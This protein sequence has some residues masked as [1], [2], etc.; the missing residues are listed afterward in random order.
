MRLR[1]NITERRATSVGCAVN[2]GTISTRR[3]HSIASSALIPTRRISHR[4]PA[5][6][7][8]WR[9]AAAAQSQRN[10]PALAMIRLRQVDELEVKC[11]RPREQNGPLHRQRVHQ[12][13]RTRRVPRRLFFL[14]ARLGVAPADRPLPQSLDVRKELF[15][16]LLAQH[17][18]QQRAQRT[19]I[20]PQRSLLQ[21]AGLRFKL[22]QPLRPAL[23]IPQK[24]HRILIM[25]D[26]FRRRIP[27]GLYRRPHPQDSVWAGT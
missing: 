3:S 23:G 5:S 19:H 1:L 26:S 25:H 15:A 18:A 24:R 6:E 8:R 13:Q 11:K 21:L 9:P 27:G 12:L 2:T 22:R 7:P 4:V 14:A 20:A 17:L 16:R 10:A